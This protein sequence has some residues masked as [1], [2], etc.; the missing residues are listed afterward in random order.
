MINLH[1]LTR[2]TFLGFSILAVV[3]ALTQAEVSAAQG[4]TRITDPGNPVASDAT[5]NQYTGCAW[6]DYDAD[7]R[8]DLLVVNR[9]RNYLYHNDGEGAFTR[10]TVA[11]AGALS[12]D[13]G[14]FIGVAWGDYDNDGMLDCFIAGN[15]SGLYRNNGTVPWFSRI[16][17]GDIGTTD[18]RGWSPAWGDYDNDGN[19]DLVIAC[20]N[21]FIQPAGTGSKV[22]L[23]HND[24]PPNYTFTRVDTGAV[25]SSTA[26]F[27]SANWSDYD[28]DGDIDLFIASGPTS[29]PPAPDYLFHNHLVESGQAG[30]SRLTIAPIATDIADG[31]VWNWIDFD[32]D[33]DLDAYRTNWGALAGAAFRVNDLYRNDGGTYT[34]SL[35]GEIANDAFISLANIW[36]D[37]DNDGDRDCYVT[38]DVSTPNNYYQNEGG[39]LFSSITGSAINGG[40]TASF[41]VTAGDMDND[42][43]LDMFV[44]GVGSAGRYLLR[45][46]TN[47][48]GNWVK[49]HCV[50]QLSNRSAIGAKVWVWAT[51]N[52]VPTGQHRELQ[53]QNSFVCHSS[54]I[55]H[56]G[57]GDATSIDSFRV[58][59]PSGLTSFSVNVPVNQLL[60]I[61]EACAD[62]DGDGATCYDNCPDIPNPDQSD[63]DSDGVGDACQCACNCSGD[64]GACDG[65]QDV[66][67]VVQVI[68]VAFRGSVPTPDPNVNCDYETT[69]VNCSASTDIVDVVRIV[70]VAFRGAD[71][72]V[73][74]CV[75][76]P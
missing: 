75:P 2:N 18:T 51:I 49:F 59:W 45:N 27:T 30:F 74:F 6:G 16:T 69:D 22:H 38:N 64:P 1:E 21:A 70:N 76:C 3:A 4:F 44:A 40:A 5:L 54:L 37:F 72:Q 25:V 71:P 61:V 62:P 65:I 52:G 56:F 19:L 31:Q 48:L 17:N 11:E 15:T 9:N 66:I 63:S 33:G 7:G 67:D 55:A 50:G 24:G 12:S 57:V 58:D 42:G 36:E 39:G 26:K 10:L 32:N 60:R 28:L 73:E 47:G 43:D 35:V 14:F 46:E 13:T 34:P 8:E 23:F 29:A 68:N 53:T 20:A 41:G